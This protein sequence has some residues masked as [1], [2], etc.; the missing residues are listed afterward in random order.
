MK[1]V[2]LLFLLSVF[3]LITQLGIS[4][5]SGISGTVIEKTSLE[6]LPGSVILV[7]KGSDTIPVSVTSAGANGFFKINGLVSGN[8]VTEIQFIGYHSRKI[9]V[10]LKEEIKSLD[11]IILSPSSL[12]LNSVDVIAEKDLMTY[13]LDKK[14][15]NV[16]QDIFSDS[17]SASEVMQNIPS[18]SVDVN[19]AVSLRGSGDITFFI[20]GKPSAM[21]RRNPAAVLA[22]FPASSIERIEII[23]SPNAKYRADGIGGII[24]IVLKKNAKIGFNGQV[25]ANIG[26]EYRGNASTNLNYGTEKSNYFLNY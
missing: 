1:K 15:Y 7:F 26:S 18:I 13:G 12:L 6:S 5:T 22:S 21:L 16:S 4:Q 14:I 8:Y 3:L 2:T 23:T 20:N 24:N 11:T 19:G 25:T 10:E 9:S 17:Y